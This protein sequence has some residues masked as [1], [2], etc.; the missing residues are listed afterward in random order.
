VL[1]QALD[2]ALLNVTDDLATKL[3]R[4]QGWSEQ[5][6]AERQLPLPEQR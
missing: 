5:T 6:D 3:Y 2:R 4:P 1:V